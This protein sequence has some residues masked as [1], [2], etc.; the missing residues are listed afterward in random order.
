MQNAGDYLTDVSSG[1]VATRWFAT[2]PEVQDTALRGAAGGHPGVSTVSFTDRP[3][4]AG[5]RHN[6]RSDFGAVV[7]RPMRG[8]CC[9]VV[10]VLLVD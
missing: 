4:G 3:A 6:G 1:L 10:R 5:L 8:S 7:S 2:S 9:P